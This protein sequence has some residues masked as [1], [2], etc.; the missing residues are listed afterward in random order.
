MSNVCPPKRL[1]GRL[2]GWDREHGWNRGLKQ[3]WNRGGTRLNRAGEWW[4]RGGTG[5]G[6]PARHNDKPHV[7]LLAA[8]VEELRGLEIEPADVTNEIGTPD[9]NYSP[10]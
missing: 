7:E 1:A 10:R 5:V 9:P 3:G 8:P 4:N 2:A 6:P